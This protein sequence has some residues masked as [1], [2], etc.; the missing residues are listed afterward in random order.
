[1]AKHRVSLTLPEDLWTRLRARVPGRKIS[2][3]VADAT[4]ARLAEEERAILRER[5]RDQ[6]QARAAEDRELAE[7]FFAAEQEAADQIRS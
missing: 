4:A 7:E 2:Q 1:M 6:Y 3:Y 5:L